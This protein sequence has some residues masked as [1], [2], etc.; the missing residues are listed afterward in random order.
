MA[1]QALKFLATGLIGISVNLGTYELLL[2]LGVNYLWGSVLALST[3]TVVG[4]ILQ[5]YW[6]FGER[7]RERAW[8]QFVLYASVAVVNLGINAAIVYLVSG[9][10]SFPPLFAQALGAAVIAV[11]SFTVYRYVIFAQ[12]K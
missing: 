7:S 12:P 8:A 4:F 9:V 2:K 3:S 11:L 10:F 1:P 5:K 6:T